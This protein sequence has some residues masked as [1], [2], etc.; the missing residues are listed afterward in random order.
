[1]LPAAGTEVTVDFK[2]VPNTTGF[3]TVDQTTA[4]WRYGYVALL[5]NG[6]RVYGNMEKGVQ[7]HV[8][9]TVPENCSKLWFVITGAPTVYIVASSEGQLPYEVKFTNTNIIGY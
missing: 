1:V 3:N 8:S 7:N 2:G 9:F 5:T 4:G 6:T